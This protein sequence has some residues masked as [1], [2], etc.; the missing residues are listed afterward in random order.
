M[1]TVNTGDISLRFAREASLG[2][3]PAADPYVRVL[4]PNSL[5]FANE[6]TSISPNPISADRQRRPGVAV[7]ENPS[8]E[9]EHDLTVGVGQEF[10]PAFVQTKGKGSVTLPSAATTITAGTAASNKTITLVEAIPGPTLA[11]EFAFHSA[12]SSLLWASGWKNSSNNGLW[13]LAADPVAASKTLIA[14]KIK[15]NPVDEPVD[16]DYSPTMEI[17]GIILSGGS[18]AANRVRKN[19]NYDASSNKWTFDTTGTNTPLWSKLGLSVGQ[20]ISVNGEYGRIT[21]IIDEDGPP[22]RRMIKLDKTSEALRAFDFDDEDEVIV[23]FGSFYKNVAVDSDDYL[24]RTYTFEQELPKGGKAPNNEDVYQYYVGNK[25]NT[26]AIAFETANKSTVTFGFVPQQAKKFVE[27][28]AR[29]TGFDTDDGLG[30]NNRFD[31]SNNQ[32]EFRVANFDEDALTVDI[33]SCTLTLNNNVTPIKVMG[34]KGNKY[35]G[36]GGFHVDLEMEAI[37]TNSDV[38][39]AV[40]DSIPAGMNFI[41][42]NDDGSI[43]LD[44]PY[45]KLG[46]GQL[47]YPENELVTVSLTGEA[48]KD[49]TLGTSIGISLAP[50]VYDATDFASD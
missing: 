20:F 16:A 31:T 22:E 39:D 17:A 6:V 47:G 26:M 40:V 18:N 9:F 38:I 19:T 35:F 48:N 7:D 28:G 33:T 25:C 43:A 1:G 12:V 44:V 23:L 21:D 34:F 13:K 10:F 24:D 11:D 45:M 4:E 14:S 30:F 36:R 42:E 2:K 37:F 8:A 27:S 46:G 3:L 49:P 50:Y 5:S 29:T 41:F 15:G 32:V